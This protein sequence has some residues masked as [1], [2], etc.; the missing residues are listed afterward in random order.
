MKDLLQTAN[1]SPADLSLVLD[2]ASELKANPMKHSTLLA[3]QIVVLYFAKPST[4]TRFS[5]EAAV[6]RLGG[7]PSTV[8]TSDIQASRGETFEDT[9]KIVS[10]YA[11]AFVIRTYAD[12]DVQLIAEN[13]TI[14]VINALTD[15]HHPCQSLADLMTLKEEWDSFHGKKLAYLGAGNNVLHSLIEVCALGGL[16]ITAATPTGF[17]PDPAIIARAQEIGKQTGAKIEITDDPDK[18]VAGAHAVYTDTWV[19]M[20]QEVG[21][22]PTKAIA[23]LQPFQVDQEMMAKAAPNAIFMHCLPAHRGQ[24]VTAEV[25]DGPQSIVFDQ[26]ENRMHTAQALLYALIKGQLH[27]SQAH[28]A[29]GADD[30]ISESIATY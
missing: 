15:G 2:L 1:L 11:A 24:E 14:P 13:A 5:F 10:R 9:A 6:A 29:L 21:G 25:I 22:F 17:E 23:E 4:R 28:A 12:D 20:G 7:I 16:S 8:N 3:G 30:V 26:A 27:G 18:A 19:S